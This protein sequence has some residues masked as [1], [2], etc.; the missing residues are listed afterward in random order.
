MSAIEWYDANAKAFAARTFGLGMEGFRS[1]F[2]AHVPPRAA[3]LDAGCGAGR[4]ALA[5]V[6]SLR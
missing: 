6:R 1:Q 4:D 5:F 2:L 3:V